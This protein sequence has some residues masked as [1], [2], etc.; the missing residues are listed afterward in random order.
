MITIMTPDIAALRVA[1]DEGD[2]DTLPILADAL[3]EAGDR[4]A[5]GVRLCRHVWL[6]TDSDESPQQ[7]R[8]GLGKPEGEVGE[9]FVG[10]SNLR[11][12]WQRI[13]GW[14]QYYPSRSAAYLALAEALANS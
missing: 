14:G 8:I 9:Y 6:C 11:V 13:G 12:D 5:Q 1:I 4:L 3:E 7:W 10:Y 2:N